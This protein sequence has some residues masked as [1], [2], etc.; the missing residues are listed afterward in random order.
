MLSRI[1]NVRSD[2]NAYFWAKEKGGFSAA[3]FLVL[4]PAL[5]T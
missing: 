2:T 3:L 4:Q 1:V 5:D